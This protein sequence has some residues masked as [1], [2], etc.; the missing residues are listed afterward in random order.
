MA[1]IGDLLLMDKQ[2]TAR[3]VSG[4]LDAMVQGILYREGPGAYVRISQD[5]ANELARLL[6][7]FASLKAVPSKEDAP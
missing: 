3:V 6:Q 2:Q 5:R 1:V 7:Y 4:V